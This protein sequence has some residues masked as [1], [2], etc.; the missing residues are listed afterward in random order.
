M[1]PIKRVVIVVAT[2]EEAEP[3][4]EKHG[5]K[6]MIPSPFL[7]GMQMICYSGHITNNTSMEIFLVWTGQDQRYNVHSVATTAASVATYASIKAFHPVDLILSAGTAG[8]FSA[9][10]CQVGD[11][12]LSAKCVLHGRPIPSGSADEG[13]T[14]DDSGFGHFRSPSVPLLATA[15]GLKLGVVSTSDRLEHTST[16]LELMHGEGAVVTDMEAAFVAWVCQQAK[17]PFLAVKS[18]ADIVDNAEKPVDGEFAGNLKIASE[19][20]QEQLNQLLEF[21]CTASLAHWSGEEE[22]EDIPANPEKP[23]KGA[24]LL[25][26]SVAGFLRDSGPSSLEN[27]P[28]LLKESVSEMLLR[29]RFVAFNLAESDY[30]SDDSESESD[31]ENPEAE[32]EGEEGEEENR[33]SSSSAATTGSFFSRFWGSNRQETPTTSKEVISEAQEDTMVGATTGE[34]ESENDTSEPVSVAPGKGKAL[35]KG[36]VS[37]MLLASRFVAFEHRGDESS[38][39]SDEEYEDEDE[40]NPEP[41]FEAGESPIRK[42]RPMRNSISDIIFSPG[43]SGQIQEPLNLEVDVSFEPVEDSRSLFTR[44]FTSP[45]VSAT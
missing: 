16:D 25:K 31:D 27:E 1:A 3:L 10:G 38:D 4:I 32:E 41:I 26:Q 8:G 45:E 35:L 37:G 33:L 17:V 42:V 21:L 40:T 39:S 43:F 18:V 6:Q 13:C 34:K 12:F 20:L 14:G 29:S 23:L 36:A 19:T 2:E 44:R 30:S 15:C 9:Q 5:L 22:A 24:A 11:V 7:E 28:P